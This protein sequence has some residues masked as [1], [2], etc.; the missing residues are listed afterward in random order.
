MT[1]AGAAAR[2]SLAGRVVD[3]VITTAYACRLRRVRAAY[4]RRSARVCGD[5]RIS[6]VYT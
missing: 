4:A 2:R 1:R 5:A 6:A 3:R